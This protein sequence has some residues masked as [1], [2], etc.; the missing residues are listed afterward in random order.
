MKHSVNRKSKSSTTPVSITSAGI[1]VDLDEELIP[2]LPEPV[3]K[4]ITDLDI[5]T[6]DLTL[7]YTGNG[8]N[9]TEKFRKLRNSKDL[10]ITVKGYFHQPGK[11]PALPLVVTCGSE[12]HYMILR[13][14]THLS[15]LSFKNHMSE[16][17]YGKMK[18]LETSVR[19]SFRPFQRCSKGHYIWE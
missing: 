5:S 6:A 8:G 1:Q 16:G 10:K 14:P 3:Q 4:Q 18:V 2:H 13:Q 17:K 9:P 15:Q 7:A 12:R 19:I 11:N